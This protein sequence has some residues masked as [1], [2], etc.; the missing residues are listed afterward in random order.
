M[1]GDP[2]TRRP[3]DAGHLD[4]DPEAM[5]DPVHRGDAEHQHE[6]HQHRPT[7]EDDNGVEAPEDTDT[8]TD[9]GAGG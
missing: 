7:V 5:E 3:A 1:S 8:D 9:A 2:G 6:L 4:T